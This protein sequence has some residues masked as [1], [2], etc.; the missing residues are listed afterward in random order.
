MPSKTLDYLKAGLPVVA[1]VEPG[2]AFAGLI[3][4]RDVGRGVPFGDAGAF[5]RATT[6]L[7][8]DPRFRDGL[9]ARTYSCLAEVFDV[10]L[11]VSAILEAA[12]ERRETNSSAT[13]PAANAAWV[14]K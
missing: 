2:N 6:F 10:R 8:A 4:Q 12:G 13:K 1:A 14:A 11:T 3:E 9:R 7:A 5:L